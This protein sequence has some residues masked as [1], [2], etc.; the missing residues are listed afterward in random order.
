MHKRGSKWS[1]YDI[2]HDI[3]KGKPQKVIVKNQHQPWSQQEKTSMRHFVNVHTRLSAGSPTSEKLPKIFYENS[4]GL[5]IT[6]G[7]W[8]GAEVYP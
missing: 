7:R 1:N 3:R 8:F 6:C 5:D 2:R 4:A